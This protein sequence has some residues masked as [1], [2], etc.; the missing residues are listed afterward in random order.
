V[1]PEE[2][3]RALDRATQ[4]FRGVHDA[5]NCTEAQALYA[6]GRRW[7]A[8]GSRGFAANVPRWYEK[9]RGKEVFH[10][11]LDRAHGTAYVAES[12]AH[13]EMRRRCKR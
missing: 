13:E 7:F 6:R 10:V 2:V 5:K 11:Y 1:T 12:Q 9:Q 4:A 8:V 3:K